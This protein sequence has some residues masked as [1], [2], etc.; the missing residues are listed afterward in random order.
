M[1]VDT[2]GG[3]DA[4]VEV[5]GSVVDVVVSGVEMV[6]GRVEMGVVV[7][8]ARVVV[9]GMEGGCCPSRSRFESGGRARLSLSVAAA[10]LP[11]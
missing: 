6:V 7:V 5:G 10:P 11:G 8:G 9:G 2:G 4:E 3:M 1:V